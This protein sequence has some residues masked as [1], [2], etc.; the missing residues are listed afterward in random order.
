MKVLVKFLQ[1]F[2]F[3]DLKIKKNRFDWEVTAFDDFF[4]YGMLTGLK[5]WGLI[6]Y[7]TMENCVESQLNKSTTPREK[8]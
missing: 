5:N 1:T 8:N 2:Q 6:Y 7:D 4:F 3:H